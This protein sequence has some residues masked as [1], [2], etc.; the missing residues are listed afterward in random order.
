MLASPK[1]R[2]DLVISPQV[3][4][5]E[6]TFVVK[7]PAA[8]RFF[9]FGEVE[10]F[11]ARQLDGSTPL[12]VVRRRVEAQFDRPLQTDTLEG[13]VDELRRCRLLEAVARDHH[14]GRLGG[15]LL[16]LRLKAF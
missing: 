15:T 8:Q 2:A 5:T 4:G 14:A 10:H 7:D 6:T 16:Y 13:L 12:D 3:T 9:R 11:V 1:L